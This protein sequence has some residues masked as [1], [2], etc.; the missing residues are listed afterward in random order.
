MNRLLLAAAV[1]LSGCGGSNRPA[2]AGPLHPNV[3]A[4]VMLAKWSDVPPTRQQ[5]MTGMRSAKDW[6][7]FHASRQNLRHHDQIAVSFATAASASQ[8]RLTYSRDIFADGSLSEPQLA[9]NQYG[10]S[11]L[12]PLEFQLTLLSPSTHS[13]PRPEWVGQQV[14]IIFFPEQPPVP[15]GSS[16]ALLLIRAAERN[17]A[18]LDLRE[19]T[20]SLVRPAVF[21]TPPSPIRDSLDERNIAAAAP[22][23]SSDAPYSIVS[24]H[25]RS[26][27]KPWQACTTLR[28][29]QPV[30]ARN[31][32]TQAA[33]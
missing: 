8:G 10:G 16:D 2:A 9:T 27:T 23:S 4:R 15:A 32:A 14:C 28:I 17:S 25:R 18:V 3:D 1:A 5:R 29:A 13:Q 22:G 20:G 6:V 26:Q 7:L 24:V 30:I 12:S 31:S 11:A 21:R 19:E 33:R